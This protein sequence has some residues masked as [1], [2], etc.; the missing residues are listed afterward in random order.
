LSI[1]RCVH[2]T[3]GDFVVRF[4]EGADFSE[5]IECVTIIISRMP[6]Y[7][8]LATWMYTYKMVRYSFSSMADQRSGANS[9]NDHWEIFIQSKSNDTDCVTEKQMP[10]AVKQLINQSILYK[11]LWRVMLWRNK[12]T[13]SQKSDCSVVDFHNWLFV[14]ERITFLYRQAQQIVRF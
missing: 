2:W 9:M 14:H 11:Y 3:P 13:S 12:K 4:L 5:T 8:Y 6:K 1:A 10:T 7:L